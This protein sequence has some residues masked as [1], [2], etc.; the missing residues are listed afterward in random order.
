M[1]IISKAYNTMLDVYRVAPAPS[2]PNI[3]ASGAPITLGQQNPYESVAIDVPGRIE[4]ASGLRTFTA[5]GGMVESGSS[6]VT[7]LCF[8]TPLPASRAFRVGYII[9]DQNTGNAFMVKEID[10]TPGGAINHHW[11]VGLMSTE[12]IS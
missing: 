3:S 2:G 6:E 8:M 9:I 10:D 4:G 1:G 11:E 5:P 7:H 12:V